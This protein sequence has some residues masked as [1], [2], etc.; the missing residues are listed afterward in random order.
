MRLSESQIMEGL[1]H[2]NPFVRETVLDYF[3]SCY[4]TQVDVTRNVVAAID[5]F[6]WQDAFQ[7]PHRLAS[8][9]FDEPLLLWAIDQL[10]R[11]DAGAPSVNMRSHLTRFIWQGPVDVLRPHVGRIRSFDT[12]GKTLFPQSPGA[13]RPADKLQQR[14]EIWEPDADTCWND[15]LRHCESL[16]DVNSSADA[17]IPY[18]ELLIERIASEGARYEQ[19]VC[20]LLAEA[21]VQQVPTSGWLVGLLIILAGRLRIEAAVPHLFRRFEEDW[22]WYNEEI[23]YSLIRIGTDQVHQYVAEQYP[24]QP[25]YV[26]NFASTVLEDAHSDTVLDALLPLVD[27]EPDSFLRGQLGIAA[28]SHFD[29]RGIDA[30]RRLYHEEPE[31]GER[32]PIIQRLFAFACL[33]DIDL[34]EKDEWGG[35]LE[36]RWDEFQMRRQIS[37]RELKA[38]FQG[39]VASNESAGAAPGCAAVR[40]W[41]ESVHNHPRRT[42]RRTQ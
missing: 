40:R 12:F 34:P 17:G 42:P 5:E 3:E 26:R 6:G 10:E 16:T 28:A 7:W 13:Y 38:I 20:D 4:R 36:H 19:Q 1:R 25:W 33:A 30:A 18:C 35:M 22:D 27:Q 39:A 15:L 31:D 14:L 11:N 37:D 2:S 9:E 21:D 29:E 32:E 41:P 23:M 24:E 8:F